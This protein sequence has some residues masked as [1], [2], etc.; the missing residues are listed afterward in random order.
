[1]DHIILGVRVGNH[2][3]TLDVIAYSYGP[4][5]HHSHQS[6]T[7]QSIEYLYIDS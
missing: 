7:W 3:L 2:I 6:L 5:G 4:R 1:M